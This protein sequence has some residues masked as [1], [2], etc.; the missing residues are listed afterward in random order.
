MAISLA[1]ELDQYG[2]DLTPGE[3]EELLL[4][5]FER[6]ARGLAITESEKF[7]NF[8]DEAISFACDMRK[9]AGGKLPFEM[10]MRRLHNIRKRSQQK[11][12]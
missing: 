5:T 8:L 10:I 3:F 2:C 7:A 4:A 1:R 12:R 6:H 9:H 11:A